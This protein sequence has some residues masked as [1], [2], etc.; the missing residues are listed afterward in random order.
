MSKET[1]VRRTYH[2]YTKDDTVAQ[3]W[4]FDTIIMNPHWVAATDTVS[5]PIP[6]EFIIPWSN[7][8]HIQSWEEA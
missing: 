1:V 3:P 6:V 8:S 4:E 2:I 7:I 5:G